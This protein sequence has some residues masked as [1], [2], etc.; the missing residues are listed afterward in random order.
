MK[1]RRTKYTIR[2]IV[3]WADEHFRRYGEWPISRSGPIDGADTTWEGV[4]TA[5]RKGTCGLPGGDS[6]AR[7]L[8]RH[9]NVTHTR[10]ILP[11]LTKKQIL[12]WADAH[13]RRTGRWP[14]R[15]SGPV[16][17]EPDITWSTVDSYLRKG[18]P[19]LQGGT[20]L[21]QLLRQNRGTYDTRGNRIL[22]VALVMKWARHHKKHTGRWP[23]TL[24]GPV[25]AKPDENWAAIDV[26]MRN[27][28]RG[29]PSKMSLS[30]LLRSEVGDDAYE[31][32]IGPKRGGAKTGPR[33]RRVSVAADGRKR[34]SRKRST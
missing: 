20:S 18:G 15:D 30:Q 3:K 34:R 4:N 23:V 31:R 12:E 24:S 29:F 25:L 28:R 1:G 11:E 9:R 22:T 13:K 7:V 2:Q 10:R 14:G 32:A 26:A 21:V 6:L 17:E 16:A 19:N 5:L 27:A 8:A 33:V